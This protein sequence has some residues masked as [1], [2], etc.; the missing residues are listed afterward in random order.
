MNQY[1]HFFCMAL[2]LEHHFHC[3]NNDNNWKLKTIRKKRINAERIQ[4]ITSNRNDTKFFIYVI[5][6]H[7]FLFFIHD[8]HGL[9]FHRM[10]HNTYENLGVVSVTHYTIWRSSAEWNPKWNAFLRVPP[11]FS[12]DNQNIAFTIVIQLTTY[13]YSIYCPIINSMTKNT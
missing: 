10:W 4:C 5:Y 8:M 3:K 6:F 13:T 2:Q 11:T 9:T 1:V 7:Q 12:N